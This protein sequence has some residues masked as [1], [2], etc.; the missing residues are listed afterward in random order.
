M[1]RDPQKKLEIIRAVEK[2]DFEHTI[3]NRKQHMIE[4]CENLLEKATIDDLFLTAQGQA[5]NRFIIVI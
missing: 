1:S 5:V 2:C 3:D 4:I